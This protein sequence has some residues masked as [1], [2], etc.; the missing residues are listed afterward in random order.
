[1]APRPVAAGI[2]VS[3]VVPTGRGGLLPAAVRQ[4]SSCGGATALARAVRG[5]GT[6]AGPEADRQRRAHQ[7]GQPDPVQQGRAHAYY[8]NCGSMPQANP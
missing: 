8:T 4:R 6:G 3:T 7:L 1:M 5:G 2:A